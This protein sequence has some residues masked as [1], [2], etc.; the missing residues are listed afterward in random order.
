VIAW[1]DT[2]VLVSKRLKNEAHE[3]ARRLG[4]SVFGQ[5]LS[6]PFLMFLWLY[7]IKIPHPFSGIRDDN[8][9]G[10]ADTPNLVIP[11][12]SEDSSRSAAFLICTIGI[13]VLCV[14]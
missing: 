3:K 11:S 12:A 8:L 4:D 13:E 2:A 14:L 7:F 6:V 5:V 10:I 1:L 9:W